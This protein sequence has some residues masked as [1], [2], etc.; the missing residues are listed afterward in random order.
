MKQAAKR[1]REIPPYL[2]AGIERK[3]EEY[4]EKGVDIISFGIGDP[5]LPTPDFII[6]KMAE[7]IKNPE[8]HQYPSSVGMLSFRESV[9]NWYK[10]RFQVE[11][12]PTSEVVSL[13]GSKEGIANISYCYIDPGDISLVPD[14]GYPVYGIGTSFAGGE[15]YYMPLKEENGFLPDLKAIPEEIAKKAKILWISYPNNPTGAT[16]SLSFFEE[17]VDF[18]KKYD[19]LVCHDN[20]Y[21]E[22]CYD[23]YRPPSFLEVKGAKDVGIE[24]NSLSKPF[25]MTGWRIGFAVGNAEV[26]ETLGRYKSNVDSGAFQAVQYAA[27][28]GLDSDQSAVEA[29]RAIYAKRRDVIVDAFNDLGWDLEAPK[30]TFYIWAPVPKGYTS[31]SFA[32]YVLDQAGIVVTPGSGYGPSGEGYFRISLTIP[33]E[34]VREAAE[35]LKKHLG[36]VTF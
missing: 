17:V 13:I 27:M 35:R 29:N 30:A 6:E 28:A 4:K 25:N 33:E 20:A 21:S 18:A 5:D 36:K 8:N 24:F 11:L 3:I 12:D 2:F 10:K 14:P 19:I 34:R 23:G 22:V 31:A 7:E 1:I 16:A 9:A 26:I 32:E 15:P